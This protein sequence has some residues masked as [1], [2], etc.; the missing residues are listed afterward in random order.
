MLHVPVVSFQAEH[1][2]SPDP[3]IMFSLR[4][5]FS[6]AILFCP[7]IPSYSTVC[8]SHWSTVAHFMERP[9]KFFCG[10]F[11]WF[12]CG[13]RSCPQHM[14]QACQLLTPLCPDVARGHNLAEET[15][16][17]V[18]GGIVGGS[19]RK[20]NFCRNKTCLLLQ[21]KYAFVTTKILCHNK[22][23]LVAT[24]V[25]SWQKTCLLHQK[26]ACHNK[27]FVITRLCLLQQIFIVTNILLR[28]AYFCPGKRCVLLWQNLSRD[29]NDRWE[30]VAL[31]QTVQHV[32]V[33]GSCR[34]LAVTQPLSAAKR[35]SEPWSCSLS[36]FSTL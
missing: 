11:Q 17:G 10:S 24:K 4:A 29:K 25:L 8:G 7:L 23:N 31:P 16:G 5:P 26:Y 3:Q 13:G 36:N 19:C 18:E 6:A 34:S 14:L 9:C 1:P 12:F 30:G 27:T 22:H 33:Y 2:R 28:Q 32:P 15:G 20:Y 21:R 35:T